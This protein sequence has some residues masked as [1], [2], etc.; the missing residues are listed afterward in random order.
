LTLR[1]KGIVYYLAISFGLAWSSWE[2]AI[3]TG[4]SVLSWQFELYALPGAFAPAIAC[5]VV[6]KWITREGFADAGLGLHVRSWRLYL[7][8]WLL[9]LAVVALVVAE[10]VALGISSPDFTL[11]HAVAAKAAAHD[12][13]SISQHGLLIVPQLMLT[14]VV[15]TPVLWGEEFGW[16]S[17]LQQRI[18]VGR[19]VLAAT[20]TGL[21]WGAWHFPITLRGYDYPDHPVLGS[22][23][24]II[25]AVLIAYIF[26]WIRE[27]SGTIW[28]PS[29]AHAAVN[30][31]GGLSLLW[32]AGT[33]GPSI[34]SFGGLLAVPPLFIVCLCIGYFDRC[35]P[36]ARGA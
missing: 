31:T 18:F 3:R 36:R 2:I 5:F 12:V 15:L 10:A 13:S 26:G 22:F 35:R 11:V 16:R 17:Y 34:I 7:F 29:L 28:A 23:L 20:A 33:Y 19:P 9:P 21:I 27:R 4:I 32:L 30:S 1:A 24:L 6:R 25:I 8:A 14:S